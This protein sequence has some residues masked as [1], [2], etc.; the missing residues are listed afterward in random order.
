MNIKNIWLASGVGALVAM[1][2]FALTR[3]PSIVAE[4][5]AEQPGFSEMWLTTVVPMT[6]KNAE[7]AEIFRRQLFRPEPPAPLESAPVPEPVKVAEV[8]Q[9]KPDTR[10]VCAQGMKKSKHGRRGGWRCR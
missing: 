1:T 3:S 10:D 5:K 4:S 8:K 9:V 6:F 2:V 7:V